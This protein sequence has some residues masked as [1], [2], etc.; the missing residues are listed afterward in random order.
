M[1]NAAQSAVFIY[2]WN[3]ALRKRTDWI[4]VGL[5]ASRRGGEGKDEWQKVS[6]KECEVDISYLVSVAQKSDVASTDAPQRYSSGDTPL[7]Q[8]QFL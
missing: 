7:I 8:G 4:C 6:L 5:L 1:I 2:V 3:S